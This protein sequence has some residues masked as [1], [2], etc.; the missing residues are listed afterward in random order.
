MLMSMM[1]FIDE[2]VVID[3]ANTFVDW[4]CTDHCLK[5]GDLRATNYY[6][7]DMFYTGF[8]NN[9]LQIDMGFKCMLIR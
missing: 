3:M 8:D 1:L 6:M 2:P 9:N 7:F 4:N 5:I